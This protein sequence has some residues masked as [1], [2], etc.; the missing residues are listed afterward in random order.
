MKSLKTIKTFKSIQFEPNSRPLVIC[1]IDF[2]FIKCS[3]S[4]FHFLNL[5]SIGNKH[6]DISD[7]FYKQEAYRLLEYAYNT[8][9]VKQTDREGFNDMLK[10]IQELGG[11][12]IFL[13]AR[14]IMYHNKTINDLKLAGFK[15]PEDYDIHYTNNDIPKGEYILKTNLA[16][17]FKDVFF[18]D[19][20]MG[21]ITGVV[22]KFPAFKCFLF[23]CDMN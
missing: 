1:D 16:K 10:K 21:N 6:F 9:S 19:D 5:L 23:K 20:N 17:D 18:I 7:D 15:N 3:Y 2:T 14:G 12:L 8:G 13:T 22:E 11:K 4:L